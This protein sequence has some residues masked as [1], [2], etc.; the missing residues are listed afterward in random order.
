ME[1]L[2]STYTR[3]VAVTDLTF[4]RYLYKHI[5]W[6]NR[7]IIIKGPKGAGK[8]TMILQHIKRT[9][10]DPRQAMYASA[11]HIWFTTHQLIDLAEYHY[12]H[13]GTHLFFDE[14]HKYKGWEQEIKNIYD[15]YPNLHIVV[16]G[17][18][19]LELSKLQ[20]DL[21]RRAREYTLKG[22]SFREFINMET[23]IEFPAIT[24]ENLVET[25]M[26][27]AA[28]ITAQIKILPFFEQYLKNGFYPFYKEEGDGFFNRLQQVVMTILENEIP[29]V[30]D[31]EYESV[32]RAKILLG[33]LAERTPYT[34]NI[35]ELT[36]QMSVSRNTLLKL[37]ELMDK[38]AIIRKIYA[39]DSGMKV[40]KKPEKI[41]LENT[42]IMYALTDNVDV[43]TMRET[44]FGSQI[45]TFYSYCMP[46]Q[47]DFLVN[48]KWLFEVGGKKKK[49]IQIK[50][51]PDSFVVA[52][53]I[54]TGYGNRI[55]LWMFGFLY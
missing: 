11:D 40:M 47:G 1:H 43:G 13:G 37:L 29:A 15:A 2:F 3:L 41:L 28:E 10:S 32:Y 54:Q 33:I 42:N 9:F 46:S 44:F 20:S 5:N 26:Q 19:M 22:L 51:L 48:K 34:L 39:A 23:N 53:N 35:S 4:T 30:S 50:D 6:K 8:T 36:S 14:I 21:S 45:D 52:D 18:N 16:T 49:F 25:H 24:L 31:I 27:I 17:S 55:P 7:L 12:A 38:A